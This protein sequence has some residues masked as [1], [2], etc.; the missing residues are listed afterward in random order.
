MT[1]GRGWWAYVAQ[2]PQLKTIF[3]CG[4]LY[5]VKASVESILLWILISSSVS[6]LC[7]WRTA[8]TSRDTAW[9]ITCSGNKGWQAELETGD[10]KG[11]SPFVRFGWRPCFSCMQ[12]YLCNRQQWLICRISGLRQQRLISGAAGFVW[13]TIFVQQTQGR[14]WR[15]WSTPHSYHSWRLFLFVV[16][17]T[18]W[19]HILKPL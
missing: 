2:L 17:F 10:S 11:W 8:F 14:Y 15:T 12:I 6:Y 18:N 3:V 4:L 7:F 19:R 5:K 16:W 13:I 9:E 1:L